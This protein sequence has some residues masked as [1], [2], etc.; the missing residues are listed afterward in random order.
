MAQHEDFQHR[1]KAAR[2]RLDDLS[3]QKCPDTS[4]QCLFQGAL[5]E[6]SLYGRTQQESGGSA[7]GSEG[8]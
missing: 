3:N 5:N 6:I 8:C 4:K 1:F 2:L 7:A